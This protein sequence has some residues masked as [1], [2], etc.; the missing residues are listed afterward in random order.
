MERSTIALAVGLV[1]ATT[2]AIF[3]GSRD[4]APAA[5]VTHTDPAPQEMPGMEQA[6][7]QELPPGHPPIGGNDQPT[8]AAQVVAPDDEQPALTWKS[9]AGWTLVPNP[10]G[11]RLA[12][13][14]L[15]RAPADKDT[16]ELVVARAGGDVEGNVKRWVGQ[17]DDEY[18]LTETHK[19]VHALKVTVVQIDGTYKGGMSGPVATHAGWTMLAAI[20]ETTGQSYFFKVIGPSATVHAATKSFDAMIDGLTP[21]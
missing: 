15:P 14:Q 4:P 8:T 10:N 12:T 20:V 1:A 13:Y 6:Q 18:K 19:S 17:F 3:Y 7:Q 9:P 11:M 5:P 21:T 16:T 2:L